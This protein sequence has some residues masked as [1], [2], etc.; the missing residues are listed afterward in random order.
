M[1]RGEGSQQHEAPEEGFLIGRLGSFPT[2]VCGRG[3]RG[4][5]S[6]RVH[7]AGSPGGQGEFGGGWVQP[8]KSSP[9]G[10]EPVS[11]SLF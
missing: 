6:R 8:L 10:L 9:I 4:A 11:I 1:E 5:K 3:C 2:W 7:P